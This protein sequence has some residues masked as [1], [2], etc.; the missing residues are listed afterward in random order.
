MEFEFT[1]WQVM[2]AILLAIIVINHAFAFAYALFGFVPPRFVTDWLFW[3]PRW[4]VGLGLMIEFLLIGFVL[5]S[6]YFE[7][8]FYDLFPV[9]S[10]EAQ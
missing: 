1:L 7:L 2:V 3:P 9:V 8:P 6:I 4:L 10:K 5:G